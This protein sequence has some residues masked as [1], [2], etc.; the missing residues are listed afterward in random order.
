M[1]DRLRQRCAELISRVQR[2]AVPVEW[3]EFNIIDWMSVEPS[4]TQDRARRLMQDHLCGGPFNEEL[5]QEAWRRA[6]ALR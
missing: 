4:I 2:D 3:Y 6:V 1:S 5:F